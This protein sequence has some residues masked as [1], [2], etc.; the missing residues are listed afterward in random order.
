ML[1]FFHVRFGEEYLKTSE[2]LGSHGVE[3]DCV[4]VF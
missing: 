4:C 3:Y 2:N 1:M